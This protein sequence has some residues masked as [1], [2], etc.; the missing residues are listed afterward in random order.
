MFC[1]LRKNAK[2][3]P[4]SFKGRSSAEHSR[5]KEPGKKKRGCN[6]KQ[7]GESGRWRKKHGKRRRRLLKK[8]GDSD[9]MLKKLRQPESGERQRGQ[10]STSHLIQW[11]RAVQHVKLNLGG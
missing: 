3:G 6:G 11:R 8:N 10:V 9:S 7:N 2:T 5:K 4:D 1:A